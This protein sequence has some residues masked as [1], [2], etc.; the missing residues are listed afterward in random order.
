MG[1]LEKKNLFFFGHEHP[2]KLTE[3]DK[4][5]CEGPLSERECFE[6]VKSMESGKS[7]GTDGLPVEFHK[8]FWKDVSIEA[9]KKEI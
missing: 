5:K 2:H 4:K 7:P 6:A 8:V 1:D 9:I 3:I